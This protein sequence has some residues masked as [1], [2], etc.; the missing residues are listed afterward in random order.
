ENPNQPNN[1]KPT[2]NPEPKPPTDTE[3][4]WLGEEEIE[5]AYSEMRK[6][7]GNSS[8]IQ[9]VSPKQVCSIQ[10]GGEISADL[11]KADYIFFPINNSE[12]QE[13][14]RSETHWTLL[15][16]VGGNFRAFFNYNPLEFSTTPEYTMKVAENFI[17]KQNL[18][19]WP[20]V[21]NVKGIPRQ[22]NNAD[23]G[24]FVIT[25]TRALIKKYR[26]NEAE[27]TINLDEKDLIFSI[28][29]ERQKLKAAGFP[30]K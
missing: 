4:W 5:F 19:A 18:P 29:E 23:C 24:V 15:L 25:Y 26:E 8:K 6:E 1:D 21:E 28:A 10:E 2:K 30:K 14:G 11:K 3:N 13:T 9:L 20:L 22:T 27:I 7:L 16:F 12:R 17:R